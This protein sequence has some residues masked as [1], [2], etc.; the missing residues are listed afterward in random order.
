MRAATDERMEDRMQVE[1]KVWE[2]GVVK[3]IDKKEW[4]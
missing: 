2:Q 4:H 3:G 1:Q